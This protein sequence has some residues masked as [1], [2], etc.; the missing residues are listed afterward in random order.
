M[1]DID[2]LFGPTPHQDAIDFIKSKPAVAREVFDG[3]LPDIK[4]RA[5][6]IAGVEGANVLQAVRDRI[7]DLPAGANWDDVKRDVAD[8]ISPFLV[9]P[10]AEPDERD[11]QLNAANRRAELLLRTHGFQAYQAASYQVMDRQR[12]V[13]PYWQYL[14]MED[15]RVRP[16]HACLDKLILPANDPFWESHFPPW[17][18]GC[19]CQC[20][21]I[22]Q[23]ERDDQAA[24]DQKK[25]PDQR[26]VL[27][28]PQLDRAGW[29]VVRDGRRY[30]TRPPTQKEG[31]S[32]YSWNP[33]SLRLPLDKLKGRYDP[34][35]WAEFEMWA[36]KTVLNEQTDRTAWELAGGK[37]P[38]GTRIKR[39]AISLWDWLSGTA[40]AIVPP[41][42]PP[43]AASLAE[44]IAR[45]STHPYLSST[46]A[47]AAIEAMSQP[48]AVTMGDKVIAV[49][50]EAIVQVGPEMIQAAM[51]HAEDF[52]KFLPEQVSATLPPI[53]IR[54]VYSLGPR[55][56]GQYDPATRTLELSASAIGGSEQKLRETVFHELMHWAHLD[57]K[58]AY[59]HRVLS[60][61]SARTAG[62]TTQHLKGYGPGVVGK[63]DK[64]WDTYMGREYRDGNGH[65]IPAWEG[66]E[67]PT[68]TAE[69]LT[70]P[71]QFQLRWNNPQ[72]RAVME[73]ALSLLFAQP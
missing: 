52:V 45:F 51:Q 59:K 66:C 73:E 11:A 26:L 34:E 71:H 39:V 1:P 24:K 18:F 72:D 54:I 53:T 29:E 22:S 69:L 55:V 16:E 57:G 4:G 56:T 23:E 48:R 12:D 32:G 3:L 58:P 2:F 46:E 5:F 68:R 67:I 65:P 42:A 50:H 41:A 7:A 30:D 47:A 60:L 70:N 10:N 62:E 35:V 28:G 61:F 25:A 27:E 19:R 49:G 31:A 63:P 17:D 14:T 36:R 6:T 8:D 37:A 21:P 9:D 38:I 44:H 13:L 33:G 40:A 64:F 43:P 20:V 15:D